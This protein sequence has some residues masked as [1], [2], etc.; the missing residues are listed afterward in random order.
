MEQEETGGKIKAQIN[1]RVADG[2]QSAGCLPLEKSGAG[3]GKPER[4]EGTVGNQQD[5]RN[6]KEPHAAAGRSVHEIG[7]GAILP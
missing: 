7:Q 4:I 1:R 6:R 5:H 3:R 2:A